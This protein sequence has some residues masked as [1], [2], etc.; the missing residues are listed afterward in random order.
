[1]V[2]GLRARAEYRAPTRLSLARLHRNMGEL[3]PHRTAPQATSGYLRRQDASGTQGVQ[4][5][6]RAAVAGTAATAQQCREQIPTA[7]KGSHARQGFEQSDCCPVGYPEGRLLLSAPPAIG[8]EYLGFPTDVPN[9]RTPSHE[10]SVPS[11]HI[12][13]YPTPGSSLQHQ[14]AVARA[15]M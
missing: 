2:C 1:M 10:L 12:L 6:L 4:S 11:R 3:R 5:W 7:L 13:C 9:M 15:L 8:I 14:D